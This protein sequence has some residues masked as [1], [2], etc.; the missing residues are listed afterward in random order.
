MTAPHLS[1]R[2]SGYKGRGYVAI[3]EP[4]EE[5][6]V[7]PS[8]TTVLGIL[9]KPGVTQWAVNQTAAYCAIN[10]DKLLGMS[11]E[12]GYKLGQFYHQ[13]TVKFD[14][15]LTDIT[16]YH[17][18]VLNDLAE[19]G[20]A[21]HEWAEQFFKGGIEPE[22]YTDAQV[23]MAEQII[24]WASDN[25]V[26]ILHTEVTVFG[27][28]YAGTLDFIARINGVIYLVD[29]KT[30]RAIRDSHMA[31]IGALGAAHSIAREVSVGTPG[32]ISHTSQVECGE[33]APGAKKKVRTVKGVKVVGWERDDTRWYTAEPL[34]DIQGYA[35]LQVRPD[36]VDKN[37]YAIP[38]F[39]ELH[40]I[41]N[42][43]IEPA[44]DLFLGALRAR[45]AQQKLESKIKGWGEEDD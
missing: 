45:V 8:V 44:F 40:V 4:G 10:A 17:S 16:S 23:Q 36:D 30:A 42:D 11:V 26:E 32:A 29:I 34:P 13:R 39:C 7:V 43:V 12:R 24:L 27:D 2:N 15:P 41:P 33:G 28:G 35:V 21:V 1:V 22:L 31:Q 18:G 25:D 9:D 6:V 19:L 14:D 5:K 20:T 37:G 3:F 38:A